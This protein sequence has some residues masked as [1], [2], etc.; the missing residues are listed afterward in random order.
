VPGLTK[1]EI[2]SSCDRAVVSLESAEATAAL[3]VC[4]RDPSC[5]RCVRM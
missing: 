2:K 1:G 3:G 5:E 4:M